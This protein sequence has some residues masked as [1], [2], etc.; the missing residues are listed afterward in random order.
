MTPPIAQKKPHLL[1]LHG[2]TRLDNYFWLRERTSPEVLAYI[3]A[4]NEYTE[5]VMAHAKPL[6][7]TLYREMVGRIQETDS[8]APYRQGDYFYYSR[9]EAGKEYP[10]YCRKLGSLEAG[11]EVL[12]DLNALAEGQD[13]LV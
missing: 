6:Q 12:L 9:T 13:Y 4:E 5:A 7:E 11:E 2:D 1:T 3:K 10:I 8:T